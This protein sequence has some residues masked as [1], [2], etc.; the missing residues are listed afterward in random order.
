[1]ARPNGR[2]RVPPAHTPGKNRGLGEEMPLPEPGK[3]ARAQDRNSLMGRLAGTG[4]RLNSVEA[5]I[6]QLSETTFSKSRT[7]DI[8][9]LIRSLKQ[10]RAKLLREQKQLEQLLGM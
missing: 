10:E 2:R 8:K 3:Q 4:T 7:G 5:Q 1:M 6:A 9:D